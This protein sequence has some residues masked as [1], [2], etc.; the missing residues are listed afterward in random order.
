MSYT[1]SLGPSPWY[2]K[3]NTDVIFYGTTIEGHLDRPTSTEGRNIMEK[4]E[5]LS[6]G[7]NLVHTPQYLAACVGGR[8]FVQ[9]IVALPPH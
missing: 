4:G 7:V 2:H 9:R 3:L 1:M 6:D 5:H 8:F